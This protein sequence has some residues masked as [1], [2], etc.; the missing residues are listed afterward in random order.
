MNVVDSSAWL[1]YLID[2]ERASLFAEPIEQ[3][4]QLIVPVLV[5]YELF[6]K[7][8]RERGEHPALEVYG[9]LSQANV[10]DVDAELTTAA[11]RLLLPLADSVIYATAQ[12]YRATLWTQDEHFQGLPGVKYFSKTERGS[13]GG[14]GGHGGKR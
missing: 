9:L 14:H 10:I 4:S 6:K 2:T 8:L 13:H 5:I 12:R 7:V 1:E 11:A 3:T